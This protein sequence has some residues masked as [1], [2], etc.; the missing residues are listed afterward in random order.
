M[1]ACLSTIA[2]L[3]KV[4]TE[5]NRF[6]VVP[7]FFGLSAREAQ[8]LVAELQPREV[9]STR[10][11]VTRVLNH[12]RCRRPASLNPCSRW[13]PRHWATRTRTWSLLRE[14]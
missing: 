10:M 4:L 8:E 1:A 9:P 12:P 5:E 2:E 3:A 14:F 11:V 6:V 13:R 7:R